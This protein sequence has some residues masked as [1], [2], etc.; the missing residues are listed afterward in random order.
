M[1]IWIKIPIELYLKGSVQNGDHFVYSPIW[2]I[3]C[4]LLKMSHHKSRQIC[5]KKTQKRKVLLIGAEIRIYASPNSVPN[6]Y[7]N[8]YWSIVNWTHRNKFQ[9]NF[10][11]KSYILIQE[12]AFRNVVCNM[13]TMLSRPH[14][15]KW[16]PSLSPTVTLDTFI[17]TYIWVKRYQ[18][19]T[20]YCSAYVNNGPIFKMCLR[21]VSQKYIKSSF[22]IFHRSSTKLVRPATVSNI[23]VTWSTVRS[24]GTSA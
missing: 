12:N 17:D 3:P 24:A 20:G 9:R 14:C 11:Q 6:H 18:V 22:E 21:A 10:N 7:L 16:T 15:V 2:K 19:L 23:R 13:A 8:Q 4:V 1:I 5:Q